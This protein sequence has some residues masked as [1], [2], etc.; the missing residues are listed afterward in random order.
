MGVAE[1]VKGTVG[2]LVEATVEYEGKVA[3]EI[4][5]TFAL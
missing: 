1:T 5:T 3:S 2:S 4:G